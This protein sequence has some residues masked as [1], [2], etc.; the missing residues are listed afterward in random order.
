[1]VLTGA[2][3]CRSPRTDQN[4]TSDELGRYIFDEIAIGVA[5]IEAELEKAGGSPQAR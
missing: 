3:L 4:G 5:A 1:M 2:T